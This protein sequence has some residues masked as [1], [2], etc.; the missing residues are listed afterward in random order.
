M[1]KIVMG[2][3]AALL[4]FP[5]MSAWSHAGHGA[6]HGAGGKEVTLTGELVDLACYMGHEGKGSK[7]AACGKMCVQGGAPMGLLTTDGKTYLL[8]ED[9]STPKAKKPYK[10]A[11]ELIAETVTVKGDL[12]DRGGLKAVMVESV[13]K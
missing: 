10:Q 6:E 7:H 8:V 13:S 4:L 12:Y 5:A 2:A 3:L 9:H 11:Q 1:K